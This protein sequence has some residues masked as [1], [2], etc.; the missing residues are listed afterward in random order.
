M[1]NSDIVALVIF[2]L[3]VSAGIFATIKAHNAS[4]DAQSTMF[5][6]SVAECYRLID[7]MGKGK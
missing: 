6:H 3:G 7:E 2:V 4:I 1:S 5:N